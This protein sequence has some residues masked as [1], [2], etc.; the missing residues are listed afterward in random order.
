M[1]WYARQTGRTIGG[2]CAE[3]QVGAVLRIPGDR[4]CC[5]IHLPVIIWHISVAILC[6]NLRWA[7]A[8][9]TSC[10]RA[11]SICAGYAMP[12]FFGQ[13]SYAAP[14]VPGQRWL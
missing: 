9:P 8:M 4:T 6:F 11:M 13:G 1:N 5:G 10:V 7:I 3:W 12:M 2:N 14:R